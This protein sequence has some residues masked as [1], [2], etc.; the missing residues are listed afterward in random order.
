[1]RD[2]L[3]H[4]ADATP[5]STAVIDAATEQR[6]SFAD[7]DRAVDQTASYLAALDVDDG[8]HVGIVV[9]DRMATI[10]LL[11]ATMRLGAV[12]VLLRPEWDAELLANHAEETDLT[13]VVC[14]DAT[15]STAT[16]IV[17]TPIVTIGDAESDDVEGLS[18]RD[19]I[20]IAPSTWTR[21][22]P[23]TIV[24]TAGTTG[25]PR[26]VVLEMGNHL[27]NATDTAFRFGMLPTDRW[28]SCHPI[29]HVNGLATVL[30]ATLF[31]AAIVLQE[32][33][34]P[35]PLADTL[36]AHGVTCLMAS[37]SEVSEMLGARGMLADS[38][39]AVVVTGAP[40][41]PALLD[42]CRGYSIP[43]FAAY[44]LT[45]AAGLVT[46]VGSGTGET[47]DSVGDPLFRMDVTVVDEDGTP[48]SQGQT[49]ELVVSGPSVTPGYYDSDVGGPAGRNGHGVAT[50][51][52]GFREDGHVHLLSRRADRI[53]VGSE[54]VRAA[55]VRDV[56]CEHED[57]ADAAVVGVPDTEWGERPGVLVVREDSELDAETLREH[58]RAR[59]AT[60]VVPE[61]FT[62]AT[63]LPRTPS[64]DVDRR[65]V[66][67]QLLDRENVEATESV[68]SDEQSSADTN[69]EQSSIDSNPEQHDGA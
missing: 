49:G 40:A 25:D 1:M 21:S 43:A 20:S 67:E 50:G 23:A 30:R 29:H 59:L 64:G 39:R 13:V 60:F 22:D 7:L 61:Q 9:E 57:V 11:W 38:L 34:T 4:R 44:S 2:W 24:F 35:G 55:D 37:P 16:A 46:A 6:R 15:E 17:D 53:L 19:S 66:R 27:T 47:S 18:D 10:R 33:S 51:D 41:S 56:V 58:C 32:E 63:E 12:S 14:E 28:L 36:D 3:S 69:S 45:E 26:P 42:R 65:A 62:F 48:A 5:G 54:P 8:D 68:H 52:I 31:G